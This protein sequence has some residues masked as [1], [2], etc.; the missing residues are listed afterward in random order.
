MAWVLQ[1]QDGTLIVKGAKCEDL[2]Q[3]FIWDP[4]IE[5]PRGAAYLYP[6]VVYRA[7]NRKISYQDQAR[8]WSNLDDLKLH[9]QKQPRKVH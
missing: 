7:L 6:L 9:L 3:G 2:P 1:F 5:A 4:R 8:Q